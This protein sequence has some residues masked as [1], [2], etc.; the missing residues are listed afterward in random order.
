MTEYPEIKETQQEIQEM[1]S[2]NNN[3][4]SRV[5]RSMSGFKILSDALSVS[6]QP[7]LEKS[8]S[9]R[10]K[11]PKSWRAQLREIT[12]NGKELAEIMLSLAK[13]DAWQVRLPDG[14]VS[15][16]VLPSSDVRLRAAVF[17]HETL[18]G[19]AVAQTE[20][21]KAEQES[22]EMDAIRALS[23]DQLEQE[24]ARIL[25]ARKVRALD[26]GPVTEAEYV[27]TPTVG[28]DVHLPDLIA[29]IWA[30]PQVEEE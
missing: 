13:G 1:I 30:A 22:R 19:R 18:F 14:R 27:E 5:Y 17:L 16:P 26:P 28:T 11:L 4:G 12:N 3:H 2:G 6:P 25:E 21:V 23:D 10:A 8:I 15:A 29:Q 24:A 7:D 20:I 9:G